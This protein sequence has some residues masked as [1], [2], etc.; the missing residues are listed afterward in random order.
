MVE[1]VNSLAVS[2]VNSVMDSSTLQQTLPLSNM[3]CNEVPPSDSS[4]LLEQIQK[5]EE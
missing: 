4:V 2:V 3:S 5:Q 1:Y